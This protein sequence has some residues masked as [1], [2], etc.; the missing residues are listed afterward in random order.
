MPNDANTI[1]DLRGA[2]FDTLRALRDKEN[3]MEIE[4]A[5]AIAEV[6]REIVSSAKVEVEHMKIAGGRGS[7]F[8]PIEEPKPGVPRLVQG[9][10][11]SGSGS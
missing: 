4:R 5:K 6:A 11:Q 2:L 10:A 7:G 3:P 1:E 8:I 9:R